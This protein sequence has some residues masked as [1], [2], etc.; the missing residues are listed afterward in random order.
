MKCKRPNVIFHPAQARIKEVTNHGN[1]ESSPLQLMRLRHDGSY[2]VDSSLSNICALG[3]ERQEVIQWHGSA[4]LLK[5]NTFS[6]RF[7]QMSELGTDSDLLYFSNW[8]WIGVRC[9]LD[10][11]I[12]RT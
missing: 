4:R 7:L 1:A 9:C 10:D 2:P 8:N 6:L 11:T 3:S 5:P 12:R